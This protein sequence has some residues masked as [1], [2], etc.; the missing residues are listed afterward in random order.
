MLLSKRAVCDSE[1]SK[2]IKEQKTSALL[3]SF[4][5]NSPLNKIPLVEPILFWE[6]LTS[7]YKV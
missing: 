2:F 1:K 5:I 7:Y 3:S 6:C 4:W